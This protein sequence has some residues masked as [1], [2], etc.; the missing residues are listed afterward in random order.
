M[1]KPRIPPHPTTRQGIL[2]LC[3]MRYPAQKKMM[4]KNRE[5]VYNR[6]WYKRE[7]KVNMRSR[8]K[9]Y[10]RKV[11]HAKVTEDSCSRGYNKNLMRLVW[12]TIS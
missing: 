5:K 11:R 8:R 1:Q 12:E 9:E 6:S 3:R 10:N 4:T 7:C 2:F